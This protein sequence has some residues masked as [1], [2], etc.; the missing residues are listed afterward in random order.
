MFP[1]RAS[2]PIARLRT[3]PAALLRRLFGSRR[4]TATVEFALAA[5]ILVFLLGF[6]VDFSLLLR[7]RIAISAGLMNAVQYAISVGPT[8]TADNVRTVLRQAAPISGLTASVSGP[9]CYCASAYPVALTA[10]T[11]GSTCASDGTTAGTYVILSGSYG[12]TPMMPGVSAIA[13]TTITLSAT[14]RLQ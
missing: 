10:A 9:G 5:P 11:C 2:G 1:P 6:M 12:Y 7:A 8:V 3:A 14:A 13:A 4:A